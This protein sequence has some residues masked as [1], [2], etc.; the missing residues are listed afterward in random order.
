MEYLNG[1]GEEPSNF[2]ERG[3]KTQIGICCSDETIVLISSPMCFRLGLTRRRDAMAKRHWNR[4]GDLESLV[5]HLEE[6][7]LANSGED[8]FEEVFKLLIAKLWDE[9]SGRKTRFFAHDTAA[10]TL[11]AVCALLREATR[12][13]PGIL[14]IEARPR[15]R[16]EHVQ[17]C[18]T[19]LARH[20]I[21][22]R[23]LQVLDGFFEYLVSRS[24]KGAKGQYF[25]PR[26]VVEFCVRVLRPEKTETVCDPGC[27]SGGF[28]VHTL[29]YIRHREGLSAKELRQYCQK[30]L[31]GFDIDDRAVRVAKALMVIAGD[32]N[33][34][35]VRLNS[36]L[37][38]NMQTPLQTASG[39]NEEGESGSHLTIEDVCRSR[40]R[41]HIGFDVIL[42]NPPFAGEVRER[43]VL[44]GYELG[45]EKTWIERDVLFVERCIELL[46][47]GGRLGIVLPHNKF[48]G[49]M[50]RALREQLLD[51]TRIMGIVGLGRNTFLPHTHQ[52]A[53]VLFVK[54]RKRGETRSRNEKVFFAISERDGKD[55]KG[56]FLLRTGSSLSG[57]IWESVDH[58]L[59]DIADVF[60]RFSARETKHDDSKARSL[61]NVR[62]VSELGQ[63]LVL[64]P[65]RYD[66]RRA[67]LATTKKAVRLENFA[68]IL[69]LPV[70]PKPTDPGLRF[71]VLDTSDAQEGVIV[72]RKN[73]VSFMD[74]GS[75]KKAVVPGC[76]VISRLRPY[77]R[78]V[79]FIDPE[80]P[81]WN[82]D[83]KLLCSTEFFV[84]RSVDNSS[85]GFLVP[86]L[87]STPVQAVLA[88]SQEGGHH[89]RFDRNTLLGLSIPEAL[90]ERRQ[91]DSARV[92][93]AV[94]VFRQYERLTENLVNTASMA[95]T[96]HC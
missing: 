29:N 8:E 27:G 67:S 5:R 3:I 96:N 42:T 90:I 1:L 41:R 22:G 62:R 79:A 11:E 48:A 65:E 81:G 73:A 64:A 21:G 43:H 51:R 20:S 85:I 17:V 7:V 82:T 78:Q 61:W 60:Y 25:T 71:L 58:D 16:P 77:L 9:W 49:V 68:E 70:N 69:R 13:W 34:N 12:A 87:L 74:V 95:F 93:E 40:R 91:M 32:G 84:L 92:E 10:E 53:S 83:V 4:E 66:P 94:A 75:T 26:H 23:D 45:F 36:L 59:G 19:A 39:T 14:G 44:D 47:P 15:L 6:L 89:P 46:R 28:L 54:R 33:A 52:K 56:R 88:A 55:S 80:I 24:A 63:G 86:F 76:V 18:V 50:F 30:N 35:I 72:C 38:P 37:R 31:W 2:V 57:S